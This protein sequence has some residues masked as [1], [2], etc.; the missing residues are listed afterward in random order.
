MAGVSEVFKQAPKAILHLRAQLQR[1]RFGLIF[2]AGIS[3][4]LKFP[5][6]P[7]LVERLGAHPDIDAADVVQRCDAQSADTAPLTRSLSTIT[8]MFFTRYRQRQIAAK[9]LI[10]PLSFVDEQ[11]IR[12]AW[13]K[14]IH[15]ELYKDIDIEARSGLIRSH[16]Y[17]AR[18]EAVIKRAPLTVTYNFDDSLERMLYLT[19]DENEKNTTRGYET[20]DRPTAQ[21]QRETGVIY[22]PNGFLPST[23]EDGASPQVVF[24]DDAFQDQLLSAAT[25]R[26]LHLSNYLFANT[27]LLIGL[28]LNDATLQSLLRQNA[29]NSPGNIHYI[30]HFVPS[31]KPLDEDIRKLIFEANFES[32]NLYTLFL[33]SEGIAE[34]A[35]LLSM[36]HRA[37]KMATKRERRKYVYYVIGSVGA[38]KSTAAGNFRSLTTYEEWIDARRPG[39]AVPESQLSPEE[40]EELNEWV[41]EQFMKKNLA[42]S[43]CEE[44]IHLV[45]RCPLDPLT[46]GDPAERPVKARRLHESITSTAESVSQGHIIYL[47]CDAREIELRSTFKHKYWGEQKYDELIQRIDEVYGSV[48]ELTR[49]STR[50]RSPEAVAKEIARVIFFSDYTEVDVGAKLCEFAESETGVRT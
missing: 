31:N 38:G 24:S 17:L 33:D 25:G 30:V 16:P 45:D 44:G 10:Q 34:L 1:Q 15:T 11:G 19:R 40:R 26:Y 28:S 50:G 46:F 5:Q 37:F 21:F 22:H 18:F 9:G 29:V 39:L 2:G 27:C 43:E 35:G 32:Y 14:L 20:I 23:F 41:A 13:L 7:G 6:W 48:A 12:T 8:Q 3:R 42:L 47:E 49:V 4:D 36:N